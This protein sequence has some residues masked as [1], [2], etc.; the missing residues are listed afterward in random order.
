MINVIETH[1]LQAGYKGKPLTENINVG[2]LEGKLTAII[3]MNGAGKSTLI[4][5][6]TAGL[7]PIGGNVEIYGKNLREYSRKDLAKIIAI[8]T[9]DSWSAGGLRLEELVGLGRIPYTGRIGILTKED[10]QIVVS[11]LQT[12]GIFHKKDCF[13]KDLSD[14]ERQKGMIARGIAQETPI[15]IMDEPFTYLDVASRLELL[16]LMKRMTRENG[17][18]ILLS[19]HEVTETL[20]MADNLWMFV[21]RGKKAEIKQG[22]PEYLAE[23]GLY[24][25]LFPKSSVI[26][27][28]DTYTFSIKE[29]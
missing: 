10:R 25:F 29:L 3:G 19:T 12:V 2:L 22:S 21:K 7:P 1:N 28:R 16:G 14:G 27:D 17:K 18:T 24:E 5:T 13:V 8:V 26:F 6:L 15:I 20:K 23:K 4:K 9:T 11:A